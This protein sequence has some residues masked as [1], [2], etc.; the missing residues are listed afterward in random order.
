M[1]E[2]EIQIGCYTVGPAQTN[3]YYLFRKGS[4]ECIAVDPGDHGKE[5]CE[6][7]AAKGLSVKA[8]FLT[9]AHFDH[10]MGVQA[11]IDY[12]GAK[13]YAPEK[14]RELCE[15][16]YLNSSPFGVRSCTVSP[17]R[18]LKEGEEITEAGI[19]LRVIETP[20]HTVGSCCYY[21]EEEHI[22]LSGDTL[23]AESVGRTD[24]PTGSTSAL[25][26]SIKEKLFVL[27]DDTQVLPGHMGFTTIGH[28][29]KYNYFIR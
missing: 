29:K 2:H 23:F 1:K 8:I 3:F 4:S 22:L 9:H 6:A 11:M 24:L 10:I 19:T 21:I 7:L 12:S 26:R 28:E 15:D 17:D 18:Y 27:P 5:L 13:L 20:G 14:E 16:A 25:V